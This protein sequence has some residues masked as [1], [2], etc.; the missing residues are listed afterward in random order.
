MIPK[1]NPQLFDWIVWRAGSPV[2]VFGIPLRGYT[3]TDIAAPCRKYALGYCDAENLV[4]RPKINHK[5]VLF[6][7]KDEL[8]WFH[9]TNDEF[10]EIFR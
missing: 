5:A 3:L 1:L 6:E 7:I 2:D 4:C 10:S 8:Y 9:F